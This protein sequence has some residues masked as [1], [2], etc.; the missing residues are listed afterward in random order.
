MMATETK[1]GLIVGLGFIICFAVILANHGRREPITTHWPNRID[2]RSHSQHRAGAG[3]SPSLTPR[4]SVQSDSSGHTRPATDPG[5]KR[6]VPTRVDRRT[7]SAIP[8][9][10]PSSGA[11]VTLSRAGGSASDLSRPDPIATREQTAMSQPRDRVQRQRA[12]QDLL[13]SQA[14]IS[15][16]RSEEEDATPSDTPADVAR[17]ASQKPALAGIALSK[18]KPVSRRA[19]KAAVQLVRYTVAPGDTLTKIALANY[20]SR[21][22]ALI[23]AI[24]DA[25]HPPL[26]SPDRLSVGDELALPVVAGLNLKSHGVTVVKP[27]T[28]KRIDTPAKP[29]TPA[30]HPFRWYQI[31]KNDRY[32]SIA[33]TELGNANRWQE[34][35]ELNKDKFPDPGRI[36]WGVR[37]KL[38]ANAASTTE[39]T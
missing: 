9:A 32:V 1:I 35:F 26:T 27:Q 21:S 17:T 20:G 24:Y 6:S 5:T 13:D 2:Q 34:I 8:P 36:Q 28:T 33:R 29:A 18:S 4:E 22:A 7:V 10:I 11:Q 12:L 38:P 16:A 19:P 25:N 14:A 23:R 30:K 39:G 3:D 37:I 15:G 31:K